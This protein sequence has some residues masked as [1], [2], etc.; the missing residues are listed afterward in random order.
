MTYSTVGPAGPFTAAGLTVSTADGNVID[1][2]LGNQHGG[3][4][5]PG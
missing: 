5:A 3:A 4:V 2:Y 1:A